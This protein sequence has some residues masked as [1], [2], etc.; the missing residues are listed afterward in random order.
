MKFIHLS[1]S[2]FGS[3]NL[4]GYQQQPRYPEY[5]EQLLAALGET[6]EKEQADFILHSGDL[7]DN[8]TAEEISTYTALIKKYL[9]MPFYIGLGNHDIMQEDCDELWLKYGAELF[10]QHTLDSTFFSEGVR[11][12]VISLYWGKDR[13]FWDLPKGQKTHLA[14][15]QLE[16]LRSGKN[17]CPRIFV[18]HSHL[19]P[20]MPS[21]S[22]LEAPLHIPENDFAAKGDDL[23][24]EFHPSLILSGHS[25]MHLLDH[26]DG[27]AAV[28]TSSFSETPFECKIFEYSNGILS[29]KTVSL[30]DKTDFEANYFQ[31]KKFV[32]GSDFERTL[33]IKLI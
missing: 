25:H 26:L 29:M 2:H 28:G 31:D 7:T 32:N 30:L 20:C 1:D 14:P 33:Q 17:D 15:E 12:D 21:R 6:A 5:A 19:R 27:T 22:G 23:I 24:K 10:P 11:F 3:K 13:R 16:R 9:P 4:T 8:G 18:L